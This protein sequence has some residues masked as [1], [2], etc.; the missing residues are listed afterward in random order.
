MTALGDLVAIDAISGVATDTNEPFVQ[1]RASSLAGAVIERV[2]MD[3]VLVGQLDPVAARGLAMGILEAA[4]AAEF[5]AMLY[6]LMKRRLGEDPDAEAK[7]A[8]VLADLR[9]EREQR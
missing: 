2:G 9:A 5:D 8:A 1:L 6:A 7:A 3:V 4:D